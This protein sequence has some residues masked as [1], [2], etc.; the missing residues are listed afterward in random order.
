MISLRLS[1]RGTLSVWSSSAFTILKTT[2]FAPIPKASV[3]TAAN[4]N[5]GDL[6]NP[7]KLKRTSCKSFKRFILP[8]VRRVYRFLH[9]TAGPKGPPPPPKPPKPTI[10]LHIPPAPFLTPHTPPHQP[11]TSPAETKPPPADHPPN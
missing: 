2:A 1:A 9:T 11:P 6:R 10:S 5:P 8:P 3:T 7:R 4:A